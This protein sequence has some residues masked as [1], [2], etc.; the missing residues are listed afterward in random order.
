MATQDLTGLSIAQVPELIKSSQVSPVD[1]V[2]ATLARIDE[3]DGTINSYITV[4]E[5]Q[6]LEPAVDVERRIKAGEY[7]GPL[8]GVPIGLKDIINT[9]DVLT[10]NG[11]NVHPGSAP[12]QDAT[13][14]RRLTAAG[15]V[16]VGKQGCYEYACAPPHSMYGPS[17]NPWNT[18]RDTGGSSSGTGAAIAS[19]M[20]YGG[21]G[22]DTGGSIRNPAGVCGVV[23]L[24]RPTTGS[25][26]GVYSLCVGLWTTSGPWPGQ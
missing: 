6:A 24:N 9:K 17:R 19:Y 15:A 5:G 10:T 26:G 25:A 11:S 14:T 18:T 8:H 4:M 22:T 20:C 16:I 23:G 7:L 1:L 21:I 3:M 2:E 13:V 12:D